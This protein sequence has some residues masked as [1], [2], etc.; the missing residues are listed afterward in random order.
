MHSELPYSVLPL[1]DGLRVISFSAI[2][3]VAIK[4]VDY[5][6]AVKFISQILI[7]ATLVAVAAPCSDAPESVNADLRECIDDHC[8]EPCQEHM[9]LCSPFCTCNCCHIHFTDYV[10]KAS[11]IA[12]I[13]DVK[14][15]YPG[16]F[17][18]RVAFSIWEPPPFDE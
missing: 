14:T 4:I 7:F 5:L 12:F 18:N 13:S 3:Q 1:T 6:T 8:E 17:Y 9:D 10:E 16:T 15:H 2:C 11:L